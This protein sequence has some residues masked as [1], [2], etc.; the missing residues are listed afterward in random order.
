[1][2]DISTRSV[3]FT[4]NR[5]LQKIWKKGSN[6]FNSKI[7]FN[8]FIPYIRWGLHSIKDISFIMYPTSITEVEYE[9]VPEY[10]FSKVI[11]NY[12]LN[13]TKI[14]NF[15]FEVKVILKLISLKLYIISSSYRILVVPLAWFWGSQFLRFL[16]I[17]INFLS[18]LYQ[19]NES[20]N[21]FPA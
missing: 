7:S 16:L 17:W 20:F 18:T 14:L 19:S 1:M 3:R 8:L 21:V 9:E 11:I 6:M 13:S 12:P 5:K 10:E 2:K 15:L 4:W